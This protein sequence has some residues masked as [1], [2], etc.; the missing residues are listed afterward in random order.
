MLLHYSPDFN[1]YFF[2][3][4][5]CTYV[6]CVF[7]GVCACLRQSG[8]MLL[9][10]LLFSPFSGSLFSSPS[11]LRCFLARTNESL[12]YLLV[13]NVS[14]TW[15]KPT[16]DVYTQKPTT[17]SY[18]HRHRHF[19][20]KEHFHIAWGRTKWRRKTAHSKNLMRCASYWVWFFLWQDSRISSSIC[21]A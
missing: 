10:S 17:A 19:R 1:L 14:S 20:T 21:H 8:M 13:P 9:L 11:I 18:R 15:V 2:E 5:R 6:C 7:C 3:I 12:A 16:Q 4:L